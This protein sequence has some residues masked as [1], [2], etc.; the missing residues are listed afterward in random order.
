MSGILKFLKEEKP[1]TFVYFSSFVTIIICII[2][3]SI[4]PEK[5]AYASIGLLAG[6][7]VFSVIS[8]TLYDINK[9]EKIKKENALKQIE[10][11]KKLK[12]ENQS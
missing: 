6:S 8:Y 9:K 7:I 12:L 10:L 11:E 1:V 3:L 5:N 4:A 2:L